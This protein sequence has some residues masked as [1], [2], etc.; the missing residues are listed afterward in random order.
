MVNI[1]IIS[2]THDDISLVK[3]VMERDK[4]DYMIHLGDNVEDVSRILK[5]YP[6]LKLFYIKGNHDDEMV[7]PAEELF[8]ICGL[9][10]YA[11]HGH[12]FDSKKDHSG[13]IERG[14]QYQADIVL[15]GHSHIQKVFE[16]DGILAINPG[17]LSESRDKNIAGSYVL[18][19]ILNDRVNVIARWFETEE[20]LGVEIN[21]VVLQEY[22]PKYKELFEK[23]KANLLKYL[24]DEVVQIEHIGS[25]SMPGIVSKPI[26]DIVVAVKDLGKIGEIEKILTEKGYIYKGPISAIDDRYQFLVGN[27]IKRDY[28]IY[29]TELNSEVW[30]KFVLYRD[31]MLSHP[32]ELKQYEMLKMKLAKLYPND[33]RNYL[34]HKQVYINEIHKKARK[35]YLGAE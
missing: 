24:G 9:K 27:S 8:E 10:I 22:N 25:T 6:D 26:I 1:A 34:K 12:L 29:F 11:T 33:R 4:I 19:Q 16:K 15:F 23:E 30:Y 21:T 20:L 28:H 14:K 13:L 35:L 2:D 32:E 5:E 18:L 3:Q 7:T 31:Y 17:S